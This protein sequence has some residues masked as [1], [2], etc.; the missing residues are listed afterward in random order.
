MKIESL[1]LVNFRGI[2]KMSVPFTQQTTAFVGINGGGKSAVLDALAIAL[3]QIIWRINGTPQKARHISPDDIHEG[4]EF[5]RI[6][7]NVSLRGKT[8]HWAVAKN[9]HADK[10]TAPERRSD[11]DS[12]NHAVA[13]LSAVCSNAEG[14]RQDT[15]ALPLAVYYGV[16]R[17][18]REIPLRVTEKFKNTSY[19]IYADA[20]DHGGTD[21]KQFFMWFRF[22]EDYE[23][24]QIRDNPKFRDPALESVRTA[25]ATFTRLSDLRIRR[26]TPLRMTVMKNGCELNVAQ[27]SGGEKNMLALVGDLARRLSVLNPSLKHPNEGHGV[28]LIDEI[29]LHL[30][31]VWQR[32]AVTSLQRSFP[33]C[34][35]IISTH[36][37]Q[38]VGELSGK[39]VMLL[40]DRVLLGHAP[41]ALGMDSNEVLEELMDGKARNVEVAQA[42][43][44]IQLLIDDDKLIESNQEVK[45][46]KS[47]VG[48]I[49]E[50]LQAQAA[51]ASL[52][53]HE[54]SLA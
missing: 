19:Q 20:L 41:R 11:L 1:E 36:S 4:S 8:L 14:D 2:K 34:Q 18:I 46:L 33:N 40:K 3:S 5:A 15:Y 22:R 25:V 21:F 37:P 44:R 27:L 7:I 38:V 26:D 35:F 23:N 13:D 16:N 6:G 54:N 29:D 9:R 24:E 52:Q 49:P 43:K 50:V 51:I 32:T 45:K 31:P 30:H 10:T 12:L 48:E 47:K 42:L 53:W 39:S 28:V 17:A